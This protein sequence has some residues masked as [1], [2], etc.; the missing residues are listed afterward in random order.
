[1]LDLDK[2]ARPDLLASLDLLRARPFR[3]RTA[4]PHGFVRRRC[5]ARRGT[6]AA[7]DD[8]GVG[9]TVLARPLLAWSSLHVCNVSPF[10]SLCSVWTVPV[11]E[12][13][14]WAVHEPSALRRAA[15]RGRPRKAMT[16][17]RLALSPSVLPPSLPR[18]R[19]THDGSRQQA[20]R[21]RSAR[22]GCR[23]RW[24]R[25]RRL[26]RA[27]SSASAAPASAAVRR[28]CRPSSRLR[29]LSVSL[30]FITSP[31]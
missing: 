28:S 6:V 17:P 16:P 18:H 15:E 14:S 10:S 9:A 30:S 8:L 7:R 31:S 22:P 24:C 4:R 27:P 20:R 11:V 23:P 21:S 26:R 12:S 1:M 19:H 5:T 25:P 2:L 13:E 29:Y 3:C